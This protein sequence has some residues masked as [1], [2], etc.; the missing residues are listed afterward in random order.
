[1]IRIDAAADQPQWLVEARPT[2]WVERPV[3]MVVG[4]DVEGLVHDHHRRLISGR[5]Y[6]FFCI[7]VAGA[8]V[9]PALKLLSQNFISRAA[10]DGFGDNVA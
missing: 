8:E 10:A 3:A 4:I 7:T 9:A 2:G 5:S 6:L 1:M